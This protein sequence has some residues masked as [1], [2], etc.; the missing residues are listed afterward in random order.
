MTRSLHDSGASSSVLLQH[1]VI[2][3]QVIA[4]SDEP[5]DYYR[6][7]GGGGDNDDEEE[8]REAAAANAASS[9]SSASFL[10]GHG[11]YLDVNESG[12]QCLVA[13]VAGTVQR[14][15]KLISVHALASQAYAGHVGDLVVGRIVSVGPSRWSVQLGSS[16]GG[17]AQ[18]LASLPLSGVHLP[19]G[20]QRVRTSQDARDMRQ[21]LA[22]G[23]VVCAEVHK[24][25]GGGG[26][27]GGP[28]GGTLQLHTR[29]LEHFGKLENGV[30]LSVPP[31]LVPRRK[32]HAVTMFEGTSGGSAGGVQVLFG[33]NG[34]IWLQRRLA[35]TNSSYGG[36]PS[37]VLGGPELAEL[38]E[39]KRQEHRDQPYTPDERIQICRIRNA[40]EC[41]QLTHSMVT[42]EAIQHLYETSIQFAIS[43]SQM[44]HPTNVVRLVEALRNQR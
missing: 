33:C 18:K 37:G 12:Q 24:V 8:G 1:L 27:G 13:T 31:A 11:T 10:R 19:G 21:F 44:L 6:G 32:N 34:M 29:T 7:G 28:D 16:E 2:P 9:S 3:G 23:D 35:D 38:M 43:P 22:P 17:G 41:L 4:V 14:V 20:I 39:Q 25:L 30:C 5:S 40:I 42:V 15:N 36:S 26:G